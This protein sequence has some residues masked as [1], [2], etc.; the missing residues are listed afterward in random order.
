MSPSSRYKH[1]LKVLRRH[2]RSIVSIFD[3]FSHVCLYHHNGVKWEKKGYEGSMFLFEREEEPK[4]GFFILNRMGMDDYIQCISAKDEMDVREDYL[5][6]RTNQPYSPEHRHARPVDDSGRESISPSK[7]Q[8]EILGLWMFA[9]DAREPM[10]VVMMRLYSF[11]KKCQRYPDEFRY[12]P[13]RKP[14][15]NPNASFRR[16]DDEYEEESGDTSMDISE[17]EDQ[18]QWG[19]NQQLSAAKSVKSQPQT[20]Q[21]AGMSELDMLFAKLAPPPT[22]FQ[23]T[24]PNGIKDLSQV[25]VSRSPQHE[26]ATNPSQGKTLLDTIF[27]S[28]QPRTNPNPTINVS[29]SASAFPP[30]PSAPPTTRLA[31]MS[32]QEPHNNHRPHAMSHSNSSLSISSGKTSI[33]GIEQGLEIHSPKPS[34][35]ALPQILTADVIHELMGLP[36]RSASSASA[37]SS[38]AYPADAF[39]ASTGGAMRRVEKEKDT[40]FGG[41][42]AD[43]SEDEEHINMRAASGKRAPPLRVGAGVAPGLLHAES[44]GTLNGDATP[45]ARPGPGLEPER[46]GEQLMKGVLTSTPPPPD[47]SPARRRQKQ[48]EAATTQAGHATNNIA[49]A[50]A[51]PA[52]IRRTS[53]SRLKTDASAAPA[54]PPFKAGSELWPHAQSPLDDRSFDTAAPGSGSGSGSGESAQIPASDELE[55]VVELDFSE[56]SV[57]SD[58]SALEARGKKKGKGK[59]KTKKEEGSSTNVNGRAKLQENGP[60]AAVVVNGTGHSPKKGK[61]KDQGNA[62]ANGRIVEAVQVQKPSLPDI[63]KDALL[64]QVVQAGITPESKLEK[65]EFV[66]E[67]L[68]LIHTDKSF[69]D[70]LYSSYLTMS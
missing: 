45:R 36:S 63:A 53:S 35:A 34:S 67:I 55:D 23:N 62:N 70:R 58:I 43:R 14:P 7:G 69:V 30:P 22:V 33:N 68:T 17:G 60:V 57:L 66:R 25:D 2:D 16:T 65:N 9:T 6:Y 19:R 12:G 4:Y 61:G 50:P 1:N 5:M 29:A 8:S 18:G 24:G 10:T 48:Q 32:A 56:I 41:Y 20:T 31:Q 40:T 28:V 51:A 21:S 38:D 44:S 3:Q 26:A 15:P 52:P 39:S 27:A 49:P 47:R 64:S 46:F 42:V 37:S 13:G 11:V 59:E 54:P